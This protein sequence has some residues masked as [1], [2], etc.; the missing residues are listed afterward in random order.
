MGIVGVVGAVV[1][2]V[3]GEGCTS[4]VVVGTLLASAWFASGL[5]VFCLKV[6]GI[7]EPLTIHIR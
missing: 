7:L 6:T 2:G 3:V 4:Y 1:G 5:C